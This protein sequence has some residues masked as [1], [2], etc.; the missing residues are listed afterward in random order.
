MFYSKDYRSQL[1]SWTLQPGLHS[2]MH[3]L[4]M[5]FSMN[6]SVPALGRC[7]ICD[8]L[9]A[10][11][12]LM[13]S[14]SD[15]RRSNLLK[16]LILLSPNPLQRYY[17][18]P[19]SSESPSP[20]QPLPYEICQNMLKKTC[21]QPSS[22]LATELYRVDRQILRQRRFHI[23]V[24]HEVDVSLPRCLSLCSFRKYRCIRF[25]SYRHNPAR[26]T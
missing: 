11:Y 5:Y 8:L 17:P 6:T 3:A 4:I 16:H 18:Q 13:S 24:L 20:K 12:S 7:T 26:P 22:M 2:G 19:I 25:D 14:L 10:S 23:T 15:I 21:R 1:Q 9:L